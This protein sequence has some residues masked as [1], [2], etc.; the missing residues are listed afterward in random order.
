M[1]PSLYLLFGTTRG[2]IRLYAT[3][4]RQENY[5]QCP[6]EDIAFYGYAPRMA[7][8]F[9]ADMK[10]VYLLGR[11]GLSHTISSHTESYR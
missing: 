11:D 7:K 3:A 4:L 1:F 5:L 8:Y 9:Q 6:K 10:T 2:T